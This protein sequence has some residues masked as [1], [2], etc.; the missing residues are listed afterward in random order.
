MSPSRDAGFDFRGFANNLDPQQV[1]VRTMITDVFQVL[2][3]S[4]TISGLLTPTHELIVN[5]GHNLNNTT[6][7]VWADAH[8]PL[9]WNISMCGGCNLSLKRRRETSLLRVHTVT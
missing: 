8:F 9:L 4:L 3:S 5:W 1:R 2:V 7:A 6:W